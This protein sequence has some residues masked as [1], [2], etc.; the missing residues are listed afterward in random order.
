ML[1]IDA[2]ADLRKAYEGFTYSHASIMYNALQ[3]APGI[4]ALVQVGIRDFCDEELETAR[5]DKRVVQFPDHELAAAGF[6]GETWQQ[7][8][9]RIVETLP[10]Q[11]YVSFDIDGLSPDNCPHTGTPVPGGLSFREAVYLLVTVVESGR[12]IVG[13]DLCEVAPSHEEEW[14]ANVGARILYK[15]CNL[16][17]KA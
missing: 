13:F 7:V 2:H 16:A 14:D 3:E 10:K 5:A 15:L 4:G 11:V 8:C 12:E 9:N 6:A 1:H 17:L